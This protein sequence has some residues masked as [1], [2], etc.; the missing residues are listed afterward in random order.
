MHQAVPRCC[1]LVP[2]HTIFVVWGIALCSCFNVVASGG[3]HLER[4]AVNSKC[5]LQAG[6]L[7]PI[8]ICK[9]GSR[10]TRGG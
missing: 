6:Q 2:V 5:K 10:Y 4:D 8:I 1:K 9:H 3:S 7:H